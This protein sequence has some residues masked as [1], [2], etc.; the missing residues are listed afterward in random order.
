MIHSGTKQ[1]TAFECVTESFTTLI[2]SK[3]QTHLLR[4]QVNE[5]FN[6][7]L[8]IASFI[9]TNKTSERVIE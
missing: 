1:F 6:H 2:R 8:D 4:K 3:T 7:L 9:A 5:S